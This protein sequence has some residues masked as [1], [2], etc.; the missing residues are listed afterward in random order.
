MFMRTILT[1]LYVNAIPITIMWV[2]QACAY[3][4]S[5]I[6]LDETVDPSPYTHNQCTLKVPF[7]VQCKPMLQDQFMATKKYQELHMCSVV[8]HTNMYSEAQTHDRD[9]WSKTQTLFLCLGRSQTR[10]FPY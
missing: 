6:A 4:N 8:W 9:S 7:L 10:L 2:E 5:K 1:L 3:R